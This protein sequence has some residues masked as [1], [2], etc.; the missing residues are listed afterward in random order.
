M[1]FAM[2]GLARGD[3]SSRFGT[4]LAG[5]MGSARVGGPSRSGGMSLCTRCLARTHPPT[6]LHPSGSWSR[7]SGQ[8]IQG[9]G[10]HLPGHSQARLWNRSRFV[11]TR[12]APGHAGDGTTGQPGLSARHYSRWTDEPHEGYIHGAWTI[13][14]GGLKTGN[15]TGG[16]GQARFDRKTYRLLTRLLGFAQLF[17]I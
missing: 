14:R 1:V 15:I 12:I 3:L 7:S 17:S 10:V 16:K 4:D 2:C 13:S 8:P 6:H 11:L 9:R 5:R